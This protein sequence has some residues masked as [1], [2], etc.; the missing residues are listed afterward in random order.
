MVFRCKKLTAAELRRQLF[1]VYG[2]SVM[3]ERK[4]RQWVR[5]FKDGQAN[6]HDEDHGGRPPA[7]NDDLVEKVSNK[8][9]ENWR[10]TVSELWMFSTNFIYITL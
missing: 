8:I 2:P 5:R 1:G 3:S 7:M 4:V 6:V 10:F 9:C